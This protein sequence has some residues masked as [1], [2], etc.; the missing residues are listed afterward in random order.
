[1][2]SVNKAHM[3][4]APRYYNDTLMY[5]SSLRTDKIEYYNIREEKQKP[6]TRKLY[7]AKKNF[8]DWVFY[9]PFE[10]PFNSD[11]HH[12][13]NG[14]FSIDSTKF[15][16]TICKTNE[17]YKTVCQ[18]YVSKKGENGQWS[19]PEK[20]EAGGVNIP[21][22]NS[23][24]PTVGTEPKKGY[25]VLYFASNREGGKGGYDIYYTIYDERKETYKK[26]KS[27]G[28]KINTPGDEITPYY[29]NN[30]KTL[31]FSSNAWPGL[32]GFDIFKTTGQ[33]NRFLKPVNIGYPLNSSYDDVYYTISN[34]PEKG[35]LVSNRPGGVALKNE[36]CCDDI[37][38]FTMLEFI[39][40]VVEGTV[41]ESKDSSDIKLT[42][43]FETAAKDSL[44]IS[45]DTLARADT[46]N[47]A[48]RE[49]RENDTPLKGTTVSLLLVDPE[50]GENMFLTKTT[51]NDNGQYF[52]ELQQGNNYKIR[53]QKEGYY[54]KELTVS[55]EDIMQSDTIHM[56]TLYLKGVPKTPII[57][58][59][60]YYPFDKA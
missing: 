11:E 39:K 54:D 43:G 4:A 26:A 59:N 28:S 44:A 33:V 13:A 15:Y 24:Q 3:E 49:I 10:G 29:D 52:F 60:I 35:F 45:S 16:C 20:I 50:T 6:K 56:N 21:G 23:T 19:N 48:V 12:I 40:I 51:T 42:S 17:D 53:F 46:T 34:S 58:K 57:I 9:K 38:E 32:G 7:W 41:F 36:T 14:T 47:G 18:I 5:Y 2:T 22:Y 30:N 27:V 31:Y 8:E 25:E 1:D 37:Y 55:T